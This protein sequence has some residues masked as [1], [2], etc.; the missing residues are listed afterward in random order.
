MKYRNLGRSGLKVS[1][2]CLGTMT[3]GVPVEEKDAIHLVH[4][5]LDYGINF[6]DTANIYQGYARYVGSAGGVAE[7]IL[8]RALKGRRDRVVLA[9]K[10]GLK[11]GPE[12]SDGGLS[13][14]HIMQA[15]KKSLKRLK[16]DYIDLYFIFKELPDFNL[17]ELVAYA[18]NKFDF[19]VDRKE[20]AK[21]FLKVL[22]LDQADF[23]RMLVPF[24]RKKMEK[25]FLE[26][27]KSLEGE[28]FK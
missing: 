12:P 11:V 13:R 4:K 5:A 8:G 22:D 9:T 6:I 16:T 10:V 18:R 7:E 21:N 1:P 19:V 28:I 14:K 17:V 25:F 20:L 2:L 23:P 26:L 27:A 15:V 24:N 3:F